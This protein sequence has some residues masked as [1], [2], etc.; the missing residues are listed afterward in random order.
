MVFPVLFCPSRWAL[1]ILISS[2]LSIFILSLNIASNFPIISSGVDSP[3][4]SNIKWFLLEWDSSLISLSR[5]LLCSLASWAFLNLTWSISALNSCLSAVSCLAMSKLLKALKQLKCII[6]LA[7]IVI[8]ICW[9][10]LF[11]VTAVTNARWQII[12]YYSTTTGKTV[13]VKYFV[14]TTWQIQILSIWSSSYSTVCFTNL[15][16]IIWQVSRCQYINTF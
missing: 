10:K 9:F 5:S 6:Y 2:G 8:K 14:F 13:C 3:T 4:P 11:E 12:P 16:K 1:T 15:K 7:K